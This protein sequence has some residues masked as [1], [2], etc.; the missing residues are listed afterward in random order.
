M[1]THRS[2]SAPRSR[3]VLAC[4]HRSRF[5]VRRPWASHYFILISLSSPTCREVKTVNAWFQ[6]KRASCKKRNNKVAS[7]P[8]TAHRNHSSNNN[9]N[10]NTN[11][12]ELPSISQLIASV[13]A[14]SPPD[15]DDSDDD[16]S[17]DRLP[18]ISASTQ[19]RPPRSRSIFYA[20]SPQHLFET[21]MSMPPR[22]GRSR[23]SAVQT[24]QLRK[25]YDANPHPSKEQ[26]EDLG[27]Q[28]GM[29]VVA[30]FPRAPNTTIDM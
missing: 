29:W 6:N 24:E 10:T 18:P 5:I 14:P 12:F 21:E 30:F 16:R 4:E 7:A 9:N 19:Q 26:R 1:S 25:L 28:I 15:Y 2:R 23:P 8:A 17:F 3:S 22:K 27:R 20:G 13:S 11:Q